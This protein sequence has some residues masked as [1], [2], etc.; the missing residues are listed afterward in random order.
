MASRKKT[1]NE[2]EINHILFGISDEDED[3]LEC[4]LLYDST[5]DE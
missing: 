2:D 5:D 1:L 4:E 3:D